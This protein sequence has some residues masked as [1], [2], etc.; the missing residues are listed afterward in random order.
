MGS[1]LKTTKLIAFI[2]SI[3]SLYA[4]YA[5]GF[6]AMTYGAIVTFLGWTLY[7]FVSDRFDLSKAKADNEAAVTEKAPADAVPAVAEK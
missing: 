5:S 2:A 6:E 4:C 7:G 3:Y 1:E